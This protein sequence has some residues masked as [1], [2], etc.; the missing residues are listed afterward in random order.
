MKKLLL[1]TAIL[2]AGVSANA[3]LA[4]GSVAP[5]FTVT[6][7]QPWL[8]TAGSAS[9]GSFTL[10]DYL[11]QGYT[12]FLDVSA[13]WCGPCWNY[14]LN[15]ALEDIYAAHGPSGAPGVSSTTTDDVMVIWI[16]GDGQTADATMLDGSGSIGNW[17]EPAAGNQIQFPM[18]NPA[19]ALANTINNDYAIAYFPTI[20]RICPNRI[21]EEV[22]QLAASALYATVPA[23]PPPASA[24]ADVAA[25]SYTGAAVHCEGAYTP[26]V[27]IQNNGT[28]PLTSATVTIT[29][30]GTTVSTGTYSGSLSTYGVAN[31]T[32]S[33][34]ANFTGGAIV[35]TVT[36]AGDASAANNAMNTNVAAAANAVSQYITVNI[37]TDYYAS[38]TSWAI[39][40][41]TGA[42]VA[43]GGGNWADMTTGQAGFTVQAPQLVTLNPSQCYTFEITDSYGDGI[44]C[45][46]GDGAYSL[47]DANGTTIASGGEF[48]EID[49]RAFKTGA[50]GMDELAT[51]AM[52][53]YPNPASSEVNVSFEATN[54][55]YAVA[56]MD[57]QGRVIAAKNMTNLNG[58]QVVSF[59]TENVAKG[60]YIVTVTVDGLTTTKNVVIK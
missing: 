23:C 19:S 38:E 42:T 33:P 54:N 15:G 55:D 10:Y 59:S 13:T 36:T 16:E 8:S 47:V 26:S 48:G 6:A 5:N 3:Q 24:P 17:I 30:G 45:A 9:N 37:S 22:G 60:S 58:T 18:A 43:Q 34:I 41:S 44:C 2:L 29:Q 21:I 1:S 28:S 52:N 32:C 57:L 31:V 14:H 49:T 35:C 25:L 12:V 40:S 4:P 46:Y 39:K 27:Q 53:V 11:D 20:Y 51:I 7:Y 56:L 50:L